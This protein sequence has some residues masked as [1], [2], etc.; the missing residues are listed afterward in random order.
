MEIFTNIAVAIILLVLVVV[1][2]A[3]LSNKLGKI[4]EV[5]V[6]DKIP[7]VDDFVSQDLMDK[8]F[9]R[10]AGRWCDTCNMHGSHHTDKHD[11][12]VKHVRS[13]SSNNDKQ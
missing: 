5:P 11:R 13:Q 1:V 2:L 12:F 8:F 3:N 7:V 9:D 6:V 10:S 4:D